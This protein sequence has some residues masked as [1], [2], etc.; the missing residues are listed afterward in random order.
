M[1]KILLFLI[2]FFTIIFSLLEPY[3]GVGAYYLLAILGPQ[4]I[5][6][7]I[8]GT[9]RVSFIV[10]VVSFLSIV[11][12]LFQGRCDLS[13]FKT[14]MNLFVFFLWICLAISYFWGPYVDNPAHKTA[15]PNLVFI[16]SMKIF[17]FYLFSTLVIDSPKKLK[18]LSII[19]VFSIIYLT[20]W[21]NIQYFH[22]NWSQFNMGR[23]H[24]P[25][26]IYGTSIYHDENTFAMLFVSGIPFLLV[27]PL[28]FKNIFNK[29]W[30][31]LLFW[32]SV[33]FSVHAI[34]LTGSRGGLLGIVAILLISLL[35]S[36]RKFIMILLL[37]FFL[38]FYQWQAGSIMKER[39]DT[40]T[41]YKH[42]GSAEQRLKAWKGGLRMIMKYPFTGVGLASFIT[43][44]PDFYPTSPRVAHN[45]FIQFTAESGVFAGLFY[46]LIVIT[47][48]N[49]FRFI[50]NNVTKLKLP[51][52]HT[53]SILNLSTFISF[54]GLI[55]CG[56]FLSLN[57]YE[58]FFFLSLLNNN[59]YVYV[60]NSILEN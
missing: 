45:T 11:L 42:E 21:A 19:F 27:F 51:E 36:K 7:W 22:Q 39:S 15:S 17:F 8:F 23:L 44:L 32:T 58:I 2:L 31:K 41:E 9:M 12:R 26:S 20:Y 30:K 52:T 53:I 25:R 13:F 28:L 16:N 48:F 18:F 37:P 24:G 33:P 59:M 54:S 14:K 4:Y 47:F 60:K 1:G 49:N 43:A 6:W 29:F 3:I 55:V 40:I 34:F 57:F 46:I 38:F 50:R 10:G 5:W 56:L 35:F